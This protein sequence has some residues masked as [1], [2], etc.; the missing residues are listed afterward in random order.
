M[1]VMMGEGKSAAE[2]KQFQEGRERKLRE[3]KKLGDEA[4]ESAQEMFEG[5]LLIRDVVDLTDIPEQDRRRGRDLK[6]HVDPEEYER[7]FGESL[8][9]PRES[10]YVQVKKT[11]NG[12]RRIMKDF[13]TRHRGLPR[14]KNQE[15]M[16]KE[17]LI[18]I[19]TEQK[20]ERFEAMFTRE[21]QAMND[22][23]RG[24]QT[25]R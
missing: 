6:L 10:V 9:I 1:L 7:L 20:P 22:Y 11:R 14:E 13:V 5:I 8:C 3:T 21:L 19:H 24:A 4:E 16:W 23:W 2:I 18:L 25:R 17:R 12:Y 15:L